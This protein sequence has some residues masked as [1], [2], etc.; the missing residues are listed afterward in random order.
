MC[1]VLRVREER[2]VWDEVSVS[3]FGRVG[4]G[5]V[6]VVVDCGGGVVDI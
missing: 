1:V 6:F 2:V 5:S 4:C 3:S